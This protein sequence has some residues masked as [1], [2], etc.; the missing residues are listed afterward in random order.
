MI[1]SGTILVKL[2]VALSKHHIC[3]TYPYKLFKHIKYKGR[4]HWAGAISSRDKCHV[5]IT[6]HKGNA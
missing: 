4:P 3:L 2:Y 5:F 1:K 6:G